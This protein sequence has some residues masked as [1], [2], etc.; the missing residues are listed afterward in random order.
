MMQSEGQEIAVKNIVAGLRR[1]E[2]WVREMHQAL[3]TL[4]PEQPIRLPPARFAAGGKVAVSGGNCPPGRP[5]KK[6]PKKK[7]K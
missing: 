3:A 4:D 1:M 5:T 7:K 2:V 6:G